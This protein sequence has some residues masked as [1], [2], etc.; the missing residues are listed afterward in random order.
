[1][2]TPQACSAGLAGEKP[3]ATAGMQEGSLNPP[4]RRSYGER[5]RALEWT[6]SALRLADVPIP[7]ADADTAVVRVH[8]AG[9]CNTDLELTKGYM[10][11]RG[12]LGHEFVG[13]V[14]DGPEDWR[15]RRVV[16]EINFPC[17]R[18]AT[19]RSGL[20]RHCPT[21]RVMGIL[22]ADGAFAEYV[23]LPVGNLHAVPDG[24]PDDAAVFAEPLAA[25]FEILEQVQVERGTPC[26]VLGDGKLGLLAAQ[27]LAQAGAR[28][29]AVGKHDEKLAILRRRGV[30]TVR[31]EQWD[32]ARA[33]LVVEA[34][35][36]AAGFALAVAATRPRGTLVLKSTV[37]E[38]APLNLAALV[39]DEITVVGSRCGP[40]A[41]ALT[42]LAAVDVDVHSLISARYSLGN[43]RSALQ[44]AALPGVLKILIEP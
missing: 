1:M 9:V 27:V 29:L 5:M 3:A 32:R 13:T 16:G 36:S 26:L 38:S 44:Q 22:K 2:F 6:G 10:G 28:V 40:F 23:A 24:V 41:P 11:F 21:R 15:G 42:A 20:V 8:L 34:T 17:R 35:G 33:D 18:C 14:A 12:V 4:T 30:D 19:C 31:L 7:A 43:G 39:I 37:A 25:A